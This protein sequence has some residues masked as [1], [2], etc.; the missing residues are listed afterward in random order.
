MKLSARCIRCLI[1]RQEE[2]ISRIEDEGQKA[3][4]LKEVAGVIA[5]ASEEAS[6]P[7][8]VYEI[9]KVYRQ[10]FGELPDYKEEKKAF[11]RLMLELEPEL[12]AEI[13][14]GKDADEVFENALNYARTGNYID[15]GAMNHVEKETLFDLLKKAKGEEVDRRAY[16][17]LREEL[18]QAREVVYLLDNCGEIVA[19]KLFMKVMK[20]QYPHIHITAMVRGMPALN[21]AV[22]QDA[23]EVGIAEVADI[24]GNGNGV[25]GTQLNLLSAEALDAVN[26][27]DVIVSKGQ[28]YFETLHGCGRNIYYLFLCK[29]DWFT[30]RFGMERLKG[31]FVNERDISVS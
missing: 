27:A 25:A 19:D 29:C 22:A 12:E 24:L 9:N 16:E 18:G 26:R 8:L 17:R 2:K 20:E 31:V 1:D 15:Y 10:R 11:N 30:K 6:A 4:Y 5:N 3:S 23:W 14:S 28:G 21:D 7:Y 13:H